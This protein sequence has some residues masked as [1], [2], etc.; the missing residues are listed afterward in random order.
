MN[1]HYATQLDPIYP[2]TIT[3]THLSIRA[4]SENYILPLVTMKW[5]WQR[6]A[7][8]QNARDSWQQHA[9]L[10]AYLGLCGPSCKKLL[11]WAASSLSTRDITKR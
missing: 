8:E 9:N 2:N 4:Y 6:V 11:L 7:A 5:F 3:T 10:H 1:T